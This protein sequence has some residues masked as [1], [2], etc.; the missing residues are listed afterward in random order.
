MLDVIGL[1]QGYRRRPVIHD[2]HL[3]LG[4][5]AFGLLGPNGSGKSTLLRTLATTALPA[6]P[7]HLRLFGQPLDSRRAVRAAPRRIGYL[8]QSFAHPPGFTVRDFVRHCAWLREVPAPRINSAADEA[9]DRVELGDR[10]DTPLRKL[11]GGML[12]RAGVAQAICDQPDLVILDEPANGLDPQQRVRLRAVLREL[13]ASSCVV[14]STHLVEDTTHLCDRVG[15]LYEG[16]L[17]F[18]GAPEELADRADDG[19]AGDTP[20]E[21]GYTAA[22]AAPPLPAGA[23]LSAAHGDT[24]T[25]PGAS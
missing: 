6:H 19:D 20:L 25:R 8:P 2:L 5:G 24:A 17:R 11:S 7:G 22:L 16:R 23:P 21:R 14:V 1:S 10:A 15:V 12:R 4:T 9:I 13:S 18:D 3:S